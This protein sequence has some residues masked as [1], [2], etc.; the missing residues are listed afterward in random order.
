MHR[1]K[2][3]NLSQRYFSFIMHS[4]N[5]TGIE[6]K[7]FMSDEITTSHR[8]PLAGVFQKSVSPYSKALSIHPHLYGGEL[9]NRASELKALDRLI[10]QLKAVEEETKKKNYKSLPPVL[11]AIKDA[12]NGNPKLSWWNLFTISIG[13]AF[14]QE[15]SHDDED[16]KNSQEREYL[17]EISKTLTE[18]IRTYQSSNTKLLLQIRLTTLEVDSRLVE[19]EKIPGCTKE[20]NETLEYLSS[21]FQLLNRELDNL[22]ALPQET[23]KTNTLHIISLIKK[24]NQLMGII[25]GL[26]QTNPE[27]YS[28]FC[29]KDTLNTLS[30]KIATIVEASHLVPTP[31]KIS[32]W[33]SNNLDELFK[34]MHNF[35][36]IVNKIELVELTTLFMHCEQLFVNN[37]SSEKK[38]PQ[39]F[40]SPLLKQYIDQKDSNHASLVTQVKAA[41]RNKTER[42]LIKVPVKFFRQ[43]LMEENDLYSLSA[44]HRD[45][46]Q[47]MSNTYKT[48]TQIQR[49]C[50][51][52]MRSLCSASQPRD[53]DNVLKSFSTDEMATRYYLLQ[54]IILEQFIYWRKNGIF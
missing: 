22:S 33:D 19:L 25:S 1:K 13:Q 9:Y 35:P 11:D 14:S 30:S 16:E 2:K 18:I 8:Q 15:G 41:V 44:M 23:W 53:L 21:E 17:S 43:A 31:E 50:L 54:E 47:D 27:I 5:N 36:S 37:S 39:I 28:K 38:R 6:H 51:A 12:L 42:T 46:T 32:V 34:L 3:Q 52:R 26:A 49:D 10:G 24:A 40:F 4:V 20:S 29:R 7:D 48:S 45:K